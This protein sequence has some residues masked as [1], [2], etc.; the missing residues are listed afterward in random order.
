M[1]TNTGARADSTAPAQHRDQLLGGVP[2]TVPIRCGHT[3]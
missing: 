1:T 3:G 2:V